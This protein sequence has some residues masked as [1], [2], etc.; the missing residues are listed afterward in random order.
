MEWPV[1][2]ALFPALLEGDSCPQASWRLIVRDFV[3]LLLF[4]VLQESERLDFAMLHWAGEPEMDAVD[5]S[6]ERL[7]S[8]RRDRTGSQ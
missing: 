2:H 1:T 7:S 6:L 8:E 4:D 5:G 3:R